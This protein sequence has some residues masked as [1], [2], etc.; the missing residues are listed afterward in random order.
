MI[1][2]L[3]RSIG[4]AVVL[5]GATAGGGWAT[6]Y[7]FQVTSTADNGANST[8][9][10][11]IEQANAVSFVD[12]T[13]TISINIAVGT[14]Q[15]IILID[16]PLPGIDRPLPLEIINP[17]T[18]DASNS[19]GLTITRGTETGSNFGLDKPSTFRDV[20]L[21]S[22][23]GFSLRADGANLIFDQAT[24]SGEVSANIDRTAGNLQDLVKQGAE[25]L[26]L[27]GENSYGNTRIEAGDLI[28][29]HAGALADITGNVVTIGDPAAAPTSDIKLVF[30]LAK[31][32]AADTGP[33]YGVEIVGNGQLVKEGD[34]TVTLANSGNDW[35]GGTEVNGGTLA[36]SSN[37]G[38]AVAL[39][40][41]GEVTLGGDTTALEF[42]PTTN[43]QSFGGKITGSGKVRLVATNPVDP[44]AISFQ[45]TN[46]TSDYTGGTEVEVGILR[47]LDTAALPST[48]GVSLSST[49]TLKLEID[50]STLPNP[51]DTAVFSTAVTGTG[52]LQVQAS[53]VRLTGNNQGLVGTLDL[54]GGA[55]LY[56]DTTT[57][58]GAS[59][60]SIVLADA[61]QLI[62]ETVSQPD[63]GT[64][65][66][67]ISGNGK[68]IKEGTGT[69]TLLGQNTYS[70]GSSTEAGTEVRAGT[71]VV[72][73][74]S[75]P[76]ETGPSGIIPTEVESGATLSFLAFDDVATTPEFTGVISGDGS[77]SKVG[78]GSVTLVENQTY[79]G[80]TTVTGGTLALGEAIDQMDTSNFDVSGTGNL[81]VLGYTET[82]IAIHDGGA[83]SGWSQLFATDNGI[84]G[85][86]NIQSGGAL[87]P[88]N[89]ET[90]LPLYFFPASVLTF[91]SGSTFSAFVGGGDRSDYVIADGT[92][93]VLAG[94]VLRLT[95]ADNEDY[96]VESVATIFD[97]TDSATGRSGTFAVSYAKDYPLLNIGVNQA[98]DFI[99]VT[100]ECD[101]N[102]N[103]ASF[104][105]T[106]NEAAVAS[107]VAFCDTPSLHTIDSA[108]IPAALE[109]LA[110]IPL[111]SALTTR[112]SE[113][114]H[115]QR[116]LARRLRNYADR[117]NPARRF[118][119]QDPMQG[120]GGGFAPRR[121]QHN[122]R[123]FAPTST[124]PAA[125][126]YWNGS[127]GGT[128]ADTSGFGG[129]ID[130]YGILG[131]LD[132]NANTP[133]FDYRIYGAALGA[134]Y[135]FSAPFLVGASMAYARTDIENYESIEA[136]GTGDTVRGG[137]YA[138]YAHPELGAYAGL[139]LSYAWSDFEDRRRLTYNALN[140]Q[141]K[142]TYDGNEFTV[143]AE[144]GTRA[145]A[146]GEVHLRPFL[147]LGYSYFDQASFAESGAPVGT[148]LS[149]PSSDYQ[150]LDLAIGLSADQVVTLGPS[151][152]LR[153]EL[154]A[155]YDH[156]F[157]DTH[158]TLDASIGGNPF[159]VEGASTGRDFGLVGTTIE[160]IDS[161]GLST[162]L[163]YD[164]RGNTKLQ[165]H[166]L[167][168]GLLIHF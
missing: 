89:L 24:R 130:G 18:L 147:G 19:P 49:G 80:P 43:G 106:R 21:F 128:P 53:K 65:S 20:A 38:G 133:G 158:P 76:V 131:E 110:G 139:Q 48:G 15:S 145:F 138:A 107:A 9:R 45:L 152:K 12:G 121:R 84:G 165:E 69:V 63:A 87:A 157:L 144:A 90:S 119:A 75:L 3:F 23:S 104:A 143:Y 162:F 88:S 137:L 168:L 1:A 122:R 112:Q 164:F 142:A 126:T 27:S 47:I 156:E 57:I 94:A 141:A 124:P 140:D 123:F 59:G 129:W 30:N 46:T 132:G 100:V 117:G 52:T 44:E 103:L 118:E 60:S 99:Q 96:S 116:Q 66:S 13:D 55:E 82:P 58:P 56:G 114:L 155:R 93:D 120:D 102:A 154:R 36:V 17:V 111:T 32:D 166:N 95:I 7:A 39:P 33:V 86:V 105:R 51:T 62:F 2:S 41:D 78:G 61:A 159:S 70:G 40:A 136:E 113:S 101:P 135:S 148:N 5:A 16:D 11:A 83:L 151:L 73:T 35:K 127:G 37:T 81:Q 161:G 22:Q 149:G 72:T 167:S 109:Q 64:N 74:D 8:L 134:D 85:P 98:T 67:N 26:T 153:A 42:Q 10:W 125:Q 31:I 79:T 91:D 68:L 71:L 25:S 54:V 28:I 50:T 160:F 150:S 115:Y 97:N 34:A 146:L 4:M 6:D 29:T 92:T 108:E 77:V 14:D 163:G